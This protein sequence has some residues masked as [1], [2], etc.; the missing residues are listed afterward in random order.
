MIPLVNDLHY[1]CKITQLYCCYI[2]IYLLHSMAVC[3]QLYILWFMDD[4][5]V[6]KGNFAFNVFGFIWK[7]CPS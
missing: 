3:I 4:L 6:F 5:R 2:T 1:L 7:L